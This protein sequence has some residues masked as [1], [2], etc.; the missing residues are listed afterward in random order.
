MPNTI[1]T[2]HWMR[3]EPLERTVARMVE[4]DIDGLELMGEPAQFDAATVRSLL[5]SNGRSCWGAVALTRGDRNLAARDAAHREQTVDYFK[6]VVTLAKECGGQIVT[7]VP[8]KVGKLV[9]DASPAQEWQWVVDGLREVYAHSQRA[10]IRLAVEPLNR[11]ET[12]LINRIDQALA[13]ADAVGPDCGICADLFHM[14]IEEA[15]L[16]AALRL[17]GSRLADVHV[18]DSNRFAPGMGCLDFAAILSTVRATGYQG[19]LTLE[20]AATIDRTPANP[21]GPQVE[22]QPERASAEDRQFIV[23]HGSNLLA[24]GFYSSLFGQAMK[25]LRPLL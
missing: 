19:A 20:F 15:D 23:D 12:Y 5:K 10:G 11:F 2:H 22:P 13:L 17:G 1:A 8:T 25:V 6:D 24:D 18:A 3:P 9:A 21:F 4:F 14:H 16:H 7:L